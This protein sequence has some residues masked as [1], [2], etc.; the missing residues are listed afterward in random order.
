[1]TTARGF[2]VAGALDKELIWRIAADAEFAG[3]RTLWVND[4]PNG[5]GLVALSK[6]AMVTRRIRLGVGVIALDRQPAERI[7]AR[8]AELNLPTDR[9]TLGVGSGGT[10]TGAVDLVRQGAAFLRERSDAAVVIGALGP[11][12]CAVAGEAADGVLLNWTPPASVRPSTNIVRR[13]AEDVGRPMPRVDAYVRTAL[14]SAALPRLR[15]ESARYAAFPSYGAHFRR[16]GVEAI[17]TCVTGE[18]KEEIQ[19]GL[20]AYDDLLDEVVVRAITV[21]EE[22]DH[23]L[24]LLHAAAPVSSR[25]GETSDPDD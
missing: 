2:G 22:I 14:G 9:L 5:D 18:T 11:R 12:M 15:E 3:Y 7:L 10:K 16:M 4:T 20:A 21:T 25:D 6:A 17:A 8:I 24:A 23:Y 13:A 1:M 19:A